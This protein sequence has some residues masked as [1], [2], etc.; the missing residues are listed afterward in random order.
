MSPDPPPT[1]LLASRA[2]GAARAL[3]AAG[4][5]VAAVEATSAGLVAAC[6]QAVPRAS[7]YWQGG[8]TI[9]SAKAATALLPLETRRALGK[10]EDNYSSPE[11]YVKSKEAFTSVLAQHFRAEMAVD[12]VVAESGATSADSLPRR[13]RSGGAFTVV[14]AAGPNGFR[15]SRVIRPPASNSREENMFYFAEAALQL[16]EESVMLWQGEHH[17]GQVW[18]SKL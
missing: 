10:P 2:A 18:S 1:R 4:H 12:W 16:L 7:R 17:H 8:V 9:Y 11:A 6:L 3:N 13:L 5:I 14:A 15:A